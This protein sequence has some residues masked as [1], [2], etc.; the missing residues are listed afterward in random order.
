[1]L[2]SS[3]F[4]DDEG[5]F[6]TIAVAVSLLL[7]LTLVFSAAAAGW[8]ASRSSEAQ[9]VADAAA[10][11][12]ANAV[13][14]F[15][16]V[17]QVLDACALSMGLT[18]VISYG[19]GLVLSC[20]PGLAASGAK[21]CEAGSTVLD[22]RRGF[23]RSAASGLE[24]LEGL[25]PALVVANS[26][27]CASANSDGGVSYVGCALPVPLEGQSDFSALE[28][29]V[30]DSGLSE[31]SERMQ[32]AS[33]ESAQMQ[34]RANEAR[35]LG[36]LADCGTTPYCL[37]ERAGTLGGLPG[38]KNPFYPREVGWTFAAPLLRARAYYAARLSNERPEGASVEEL[39]DSA[40]RRA[41]YE[42]AL[43]EVSAGYYV[44]HEG[45]TVSMDLPSL[46]S[47]AEETS[48]C[49][50]YTSVSWPCTAEA[51]GRVLHCSEECPGATGG[52]AG[53]SSLA[54]IDSGAV[55]TCPVCKMDVGELGRVAAASTSI[56]NGFEHHWRLVVGAAE[57]Y[58]EA[59]NAWAAAEG[60]TR[61][62]AAEGEDS[63]E[64]ALD[65]LSATR[66]TL[67]PPGAWGCVAVVAR[68]EGETV[69]TEL[70]RSFLSSAEL[71]AGAAISAAVLA[72]DETTDTEGVLSSFFD[73]LG[74]DSLL[75]GTADGVME[76]WE[77]LLSGYGSVAEAGGEFLGSLDGVLGG[78][79]GSWLRERLKGVLVDTGLE[80]VDLRLR[81]P[82]LAN[83]QDVLEQG[84]FDQG[85]TV[86][87]ALSELRGAASATDLARWAG[88]ALEGMGGL[89]EI[90]VAE[91][92]VPGTGLSIPLRI[93]LSF[94]GE[95]A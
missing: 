55:S 77:R 49:E 93:D 5:G 21:M 41:F 40:C 32:E 88:L 1:M 23:V 22:A 68:G 69:P 9:R 35:H 79:A 2:V 50:L 60:R 7:S 44:E 37:R 85:S 33:E 16:T 87:E 19:A 64:Q 71:P 65:Q 10:M 78:S 70:T 63:F 95:V 11:A 80:P 28:A 42:Y 72:P 86:R 48:A 6:T 13:A 84:G 27:S 62:L 89:S 83:S 24:R 26:A 58:E 90:T 46:P 43:A 20:V 30:D 92:P 3:L 45:G 94:L 15:S 82:V 76:L 39:T 61:E 66:P 81:K 73:S 31:L 18:G 91:I 54:E 36:W 67:C 17:A 4:R 29:E 8:V 57:D 34:E 56:E 75:G 12:G 38:A 25:L 74:A 47:N 14:A 59:R 52:P 53:L 51:A